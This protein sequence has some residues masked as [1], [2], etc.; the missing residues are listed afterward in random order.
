MTRPAPR[1]LDD[2]AGWL[3]RVR[4]LLTSCDLSGAHPDDLADIRAGLIQ[5]TDLARALESTSGV[6][7]V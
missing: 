2:M 1:D 4:D 3:L 5:L 6:S 7:D